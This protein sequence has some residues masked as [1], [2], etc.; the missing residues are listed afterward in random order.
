MKKKWYLG[1]ALIMSALT[2]VA[3]DND[4]VNGDGHGITVSKDVAAAFAKMY[5]N[6]GNAKWSTKGGYLVA[7]FTE[8]G[9]T[10]TAYFDEQ[11]EWFMTDTDIETNALPQVISQA[12]KASKWSTWR[13]DDVDVIK[14]EG[15][16]E[17]YSVELEKGNE[18]IELIFS[19]NGKLLEVIIDEDDDDDD[20]DHSEHIVPEIPASIEKY[21]NDNYP[22]A[23]IL[24]RD[25]D[26]DGVEVDIYFNNKKIELTFT[27][28]GKW[29]STETEYENG[30]AP[31]F[32]KAAIAAK[33]PGAVIEDA[34]HYKSATKEYCEV[35][36]KVA[37]KEYELRVTADGTITVLDVD[38]DNDNDDNDNDDNDDNDDDNDDNDNDNDDNDDDNDND[39]D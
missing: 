4:N 3:C 29:I 22:N 19:A 17:I 25:T 10:N 38:N 30:D 11:G 16:E 6:A 13:V 33:Y 8:K 20:D 23:K 18:E 14:R 12:I 32:A 7:D 5:P 21:I 35:E 28:A 24:D 2:S 9:N 37:G 26:D 27:A 34:D 39:N 15:T 31:E 1:A 36:I